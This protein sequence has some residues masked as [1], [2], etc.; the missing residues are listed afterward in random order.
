M[1]WIGWIWDGSRWLDVCE[2]R[3]MAAC[4]RRLSAE[5]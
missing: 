2:G 4:S 5:A 3:S 1:S